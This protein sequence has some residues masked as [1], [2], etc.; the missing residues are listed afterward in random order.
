MGM[1]NTQGWKMNAP[2]D[3]TE[4]IETSSR[5]IEPGGV[6][7]VEKPVSF[8]NPIGLSDFNQLV[9][10]Y[11]DRV[12]QQAYRL[13]GDHQSADDATQESFIIAFR[14][15]HTYR[16][17]SLAGWL[18][19]IVTN[20]CIDEIRR[21]KRSRVISLEPI[22]DN[23][24]E[25][26]SPGWIADPG[27]LPEEAAERFELRE[28]IQSVINKLAPDYRTALVLVDIQGLDYAE[29]AGV[30]GC[31]VGTVKSRLARARSRLRAYLEAGS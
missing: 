24:E 27:E 29:A 17:G 15:F 13:L 10:E 5:G 8:H 25:I 20:L 18:L 3:R 1:S 6:F 9:L 22:D 11:Q 30:L 31:P 21:R 26:E 2:F 12:Y 28:K 14:K 7:P 16:G 23:G 19:R 4:P